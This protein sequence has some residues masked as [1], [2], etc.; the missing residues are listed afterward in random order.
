M[1]AIFGTTS[2]SSISFEIRSL[3]HKQISLLGTTI[4]SPQEF[5][6]MLRAVDSGSLK[7]IIDRIFPL[8]EARAAHQRLEQ[9]EH[10]GKIILTVP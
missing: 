9:R 4:G 2:G 5:S 6:Q 10:F 7:P 3:Y 1:W 8:P